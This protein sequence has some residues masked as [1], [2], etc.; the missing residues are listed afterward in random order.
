[1]NKTLDQLMQKFVLVKT[2]EECWLWMGSIKTSGY[3]Q[4]SWKSKSRPAHRVIA[5]L[6]FNWD[7]N[8]QTFEVMHS[9]NNKRCCNWNH[10]TK[11]THQE[12]LI[13]ASKTGLLK[14]NG[15]GGV[16]INTIPDWERPAATEWQTS[17]VR[18][19]LKNAIYQTRLV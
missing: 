15:G 1:M 14:N 6:K 9:C 18:I 17:R 16:L 12:N 2:K 4:V 11:G 13:H 3:G 5:C 8:D 10:L 19:T 7:I